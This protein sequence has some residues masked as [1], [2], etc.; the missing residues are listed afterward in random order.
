[1]IPRMKIVKARW[2]PAPSLSPHTPDLISGPERPWATPL[3]K[4]PGQIERLRKK[5][6]EWRGRL[7]RLDESIHEARRAGVLLA[8]IGDRHEILALQV[9]DQRVIR[10]VA[11]RRA[12]QLVAG[13][14]AGCAEFPAADRAL[15]FFGMRDDRVANLRQRRALRMPQAASGED[16]ADREMEIV[17]GRVDSAPSRGVM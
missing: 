5:S 4:S 6:H 12:L 9:L 8:Q 1:M 2:F 14:L 10:V 7:A 17:A 15:P 13:E 3:P 16:L 11:L